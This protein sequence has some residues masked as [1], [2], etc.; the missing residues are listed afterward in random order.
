[1]KEDTKEYAAPA[2]VTRQDIAAGLRSIGI[3]AKDKVM[4][5]SSLKSFGRVEGGARTVISALQE[6][7]TPAGILA[8]PAFSDCSDGG[9][10]GPFDPE[11]SPVETWVGLIPETFR[12]QP[13]VIRSLHPTHSVCAWG[14]DAARFLSQKD[15]WDI[16]SPDSPWGKLHEEGGKILFFGESVGGNTFLHACEAWFNTYLDSTMAWIKTPDGPRQVRVTNYPGGCRGGWYKLK[17]QAP[18]Y[19]KLDAMGVYH[20]GKI[21]DAVVTVCRAD[22]LAA[23]MNK[24]F[25]EDPAILLHKEGCP[26]CAR[27]RSKIL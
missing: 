24:L 4:V 10:Q 15:P 17:R 9:A 25:A 23:G 7:I 18:Y 3:T 27:V 5:H 8:M 20:Y 22:E 12:H 6:V 2:E 1:M 13:G 21:G 14:N 26:G 16:F 11:T 19:L